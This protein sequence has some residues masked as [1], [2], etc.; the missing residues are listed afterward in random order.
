[1]GLLTDTKINSNLTTVPEA[2]RNY[3]SLESGDRVEWYVEDG[4]VVVRRKED[5]TAEETPE[6]AD[7]AGSHA[8]GEGR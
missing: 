6:A 3:L 5:A 2:V 1:M 4:D 7:P 8:A